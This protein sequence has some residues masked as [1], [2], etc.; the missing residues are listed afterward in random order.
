VLKVNL[1]M[2]KRKDLLSKALVDFSKIIFTGLVI[3]KFIY[4]DKISLFVSLL[5]LAGVLLLMFLAW[6]VVPLKEAE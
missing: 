1:I 6:Y 4:T 3:G 5:G 2:D